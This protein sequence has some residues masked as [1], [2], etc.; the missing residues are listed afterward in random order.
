VAV[1]DLDSEIAAAK[2]SAAEAQQEVERERTAF[3]DAAAEAVPRWWQR[4][5]EDAVKRR[6]DVAMALGK[7]TV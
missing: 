3:L 6:P 2:S 1:T 4:A 7:R 5:V